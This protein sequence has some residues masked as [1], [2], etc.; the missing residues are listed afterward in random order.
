[1]ENELEKAIG[2]VFRNRAI[3]ENA[4][5]HSSYANENRDRGCQDN[6]RLEFLGD[7]VLGF[8]TAEFLYENFPTKPEGELTRIRAALVCESSLAKAAR[9]IGLGKE[10]LLG[11]G[12]DNN[13][14]RDRDSI[15]S[16]AME[17]VFAAVYLDGGFSPAR[18][19]IRRILLDDSH[20][21]KTSSLDY[22][23]MLQELVQR[24]KNQVIRYDMIRE[25]GPD[26]DKTFEVLVCVNGREAGR[27]KG[28]SK[29]RAE[30]NA[31]ENGIRAL[32][33]GEL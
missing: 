33:P 19:L 14:G 27:G 21:K 26:H 22:K 8:V 20:V 30:Q 3:L 29:K 13:G 32:F 2:Y 23:T 25:Y 12:E 9:G 17:S 18:D 31:A 24:K 6:E 10:L 11:Q 1:M 4:L 16:D 15:L 5:T 28:S 7:S